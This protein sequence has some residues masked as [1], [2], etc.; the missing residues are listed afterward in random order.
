MSMSDQ[1]VAEAALAREAPIARSGAF[2]E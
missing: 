2:G 1:A